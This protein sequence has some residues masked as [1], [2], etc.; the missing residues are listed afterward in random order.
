MNPYLAQ[1]N[2][3]ENVKYRQ[4]LAHQIAEL[5]RKAYPFTQMTRAEL[6]AEHE[7]GFSNWV[8]LM[9]LTEAVGIKTNE[10]AEEIQI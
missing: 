3:E 1:Q 8:V 7:C 9:W 10:L 6:E 2:R 5:G 4:H